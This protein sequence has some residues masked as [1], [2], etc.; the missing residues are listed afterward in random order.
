[1]FREISLSLFHGISKQGSTGRKVGFLV[2][3]IRL[4][5]GATA[6]PVIAQVQENSLQH[7]AAVCMCLCIDR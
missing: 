3:D 5:I 1:M 4:D 2:L 6:E 7:C